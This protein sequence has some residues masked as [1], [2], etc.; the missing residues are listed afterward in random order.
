MSIE[1]IFA[2]LFL[3]ILTLFLIKERKRL[4]IQRMI[5]PIFQFKQY[6]KKIDALIFEGIELAKEGK[7]N[8][9]NDLFDKALRIKLKDPKHIDEL[10]YKGLTQ[11]HLGKHREAIK[12]F[13]ELIK[14]ELKHPEKID[15]LIYKGIALSKLAEHKEAI[16]CFDKA[17]KFNIHIPILY[18]ALYKTK[19]G[20]KQMDS[21]SKKHPKL[22]DF[23]SKAGVY[24]GILGI[25]LIA[26]LCLK[27]LY[28]IFFVAHAAA[29]VALVLPFKVK[30]GFYVPFFYWIISIFFIATIHEFC[31]GVVAR[32]HKIPIKS[33][34][35]AFL[36]LVV[37]V[38]PA[39]FVEP[40]EKLLAKKKR[41][42]KL[43]VFAAGPFSNIISG[44]IVLLI[45]LLLSV[46][47]AS[48]VIQPDGVNIEGY[49]DTNTS[50]AKLA[51][52]PENT[53]IKEMDGVEILY[54]DNI[55]SALANR[56]PKDFVNLTT[57][58]GT[59]QIKLGSHPENSSLPY[60]GLLL[61]QA[62]KTKSSFE[63]KYSSF[64]APVIMWFMGLF[65]WV[66]LLSLGIGLFNLIPIGPVDGGQM[67]REMFMQFF[68]K[69]TALKLWQWTSLFFFAVIMLTLLSGF[70]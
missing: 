63:Q 28:D 68:R 70:F 37:P 31:H 41:M 14:K 38:I 10:I 30:G 61:S 55:S 4:I 46:P 62:Q 42:Q 57:T 13:D 58:N 21:I 49:T 67:T 43:S 20:L 59:Y 24:I 40:D 35:F 50:A 2:I 16:A 3:V 7:H 29:G 39:A 1:T 34:G 69:E 66:Y 9:A 5:W 44:G 11:Y 52:V 25:F 15:A 54:V 53:K 26:W 12:C 48:Y 47:V 6:T 60:L 51:G 45:F 36:G 18:F 17:L 56:K 65:Y 22:V 8:Q 32:L 19:L 23:V 27:S 33:S 64:A